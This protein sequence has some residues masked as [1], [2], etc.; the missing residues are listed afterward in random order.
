MVES[1]LLRKAQM[2]M[3]EILKVIDI[4]CI[5]HNIKWWLHYGTALGA[6]R[7][8]GFIPWDDDCDIAMMR[9]DYERF[10][11]VVEKELPENM[12]FQTR[13]SDPYYPRKIAKIRMKNTKLVEFDENEN[14]K[15]HQGIFV[16][17]FVQ[18]YYPQSHKKFLKLWN[19]VL[20]MK[21]R[22]KQ[23][24]KGSWQRMAIQ[25][26]IVI[27]Y[28]F[29]SIV[30]KSYKVVSVMF[31]K[32]V[33]LYYI[34]NEI[35]LYDNKFLKKEWIFPLQRSVE[36]EGQYFPMPN[37]WDSYLKEHYGDYMKLPPVEQRYIHAKNIEC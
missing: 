3:I 24:S 10:I 35:N 9:T 33:D 11:K 26:G 2:K 19:K 15:Y 4:I 30:M 22:R 34:G 37:N 20:S 27:P 5:K 6:V 13:E 36:F 14:E 16:D 21:Y 17:I 23:Y 31:R 29:Y 1:Q 8:N 25:V 18:D 12:F 32:N 7:H 28:L